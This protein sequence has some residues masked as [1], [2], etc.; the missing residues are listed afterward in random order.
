MKPQRSVLYK[1]F[2][3][4]IFFIFVIVSIVIWKS[5][6]NWW[7]WIASAT[8]TTIAVIFLAW[9][10]ENAWYSKLDLKDHLTLRLD[11]FK[12]ITQILG[13]ILLLVGLYFT[14]RNF[15]ASQDKQ[16]TDL[17]VQ[18]VGQLQSGELMV[19]LGGAYALDRIARD[20]AKDYCTIMEILTAYVR[21]KAAWK[22]EPDV[23]TPG[24]EVEP[25]QVDPKSVIRPP[26]DIQAI[27]TM[28]AC[29]LEKNRCLEKNPLDLRRTNL[30]G[31][32]LER[33]FLNKILL[34]KTN[35]AQANLNGAQLQEADLTEGSLRKSH[36]RR[37]ILF[38]A[39]LHKANL[40]GANLTD[41]SLGQADLSEASLKGSTLLGTTL[42]HAV[43][44]KTNLREANLGYANLN[45]ASLYMAFLEKAKLNQASLKGASLEGAHLT[46]ADFC[47]A[48]LEN[49]NL[50]EAH[51][52]NTKLWEANLKGANFESADLQYAIFSKTHLEGADLSK[53]IGLTRDQLKNA[54]IDKTTKLPDY[55]K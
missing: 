54:F 16:V 22:E 44:S 15:V 1:V 33:A 25:Q 37:S 55:L 41:A 45:R 52:E 14:Y 5:N 28:I 29:R 35:L 40:D 4:A 47:K 18:A 48:D 20:S 26:A 49:A 24:P 27:L 43:L 10:Y 53:A 50:R 13:G 6:A 17:Y 39:I 11:L 21:E 38:K 34:Q 31:A 19:R 36:L 3:A 51:L 42:D 32:E 9:R 2:S 7:V 23:N 8:I 30:Q 46:D 12:T